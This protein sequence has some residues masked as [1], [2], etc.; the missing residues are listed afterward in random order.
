MKFVHFF[1]FYNF[2]IWTFNQSFLDFKFH[3]SGKFRAYRYSTTLSASP[4]LIHISKANF[5]ILLKQSY[6]LI[7]NPTLAYGTQVQSIL[8]LGVVCLHSIPKKV[9]K[10]YLRFE[11]HPSV[12]IFLPLDLSLK[13]K[14]L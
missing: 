11:V 13:A 3:L 12:Q 4:L 14:L 1:K 9:F 6:S 5:S 7:S 2:G 10:P 8:G